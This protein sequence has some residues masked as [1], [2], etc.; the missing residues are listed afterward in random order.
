[1]AV[2]QAGAFL[3]DIIAQPDDDAV[4]L[5][6]ADWLE[7][8]LDEA[9]RARAEFIRAQVE[10]ASLHPAHPRRRALLQRETRLLARH[11]AAWAGRVAALSRGWRFH[12]G[13][14]E[15]AVLG[16]DNFLPAT[17]E[18]FALAPVSH[19]RLRDTPRLAHLAGVA[20]EV[21]QA[22]ADRFCR[23]K[24]L[25]LRN[26]RVGAAAAESFLGLPRLPRLEALFLGR[27]SLAA[28]GAF[29]ERWVELLGSLKTLQVGSA[30]GADGIGFLLHSLPLP[31]LES[32]SLSGARLG[33]RFVTMLG[34]SPLAGKLRSLSLGHGA[35]TAEGVRELFDS[36]LAE[37]LESLDLSF[38]GLTAEGARVLAEARPP[39]RL[40]LLNL[41][42]TFLGDAGVR[43]LADSP[44]FGQLLGLDLS[45]NLVGP[46]GA[47]ALAA[48]RA[49]A[50]LMTLDLIYNPLGGES[51][52]LLVDRYGEE[53][54][55]FD[56]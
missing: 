33:D 5:I 50:G 31:R 56:R 43:L 49:P 46:G 6:F 40:T 17:E 13:F 8:Q 29:H 51:R 30:A 36:P 20:A 7:D 24:T 37:T 48:R 53:V 26:E 3:Q 47:A 18:L 44:L 25:D 38:N 9:S 11:E 16:I 12:R 35:L 32:L 27:N 52:R 10:R 54:C 41:S 34:G 21:R 23:I 2:D 45:L 22:W 55:L 39:P 15:E 1:M 19:L 42:R 14:I 4:R 28:S